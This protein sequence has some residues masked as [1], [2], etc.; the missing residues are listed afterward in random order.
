M[1][2]RSPTLEEKRAYYAKVRAANYTASLRLEGFVVPPS[3]KEPMPTP[4][5][6]PD[7]PSTTTVNPPP[8]L[9]SS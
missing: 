4:V 8:D 7:L 1:A 2:H 5:D 3:S 9:P 6:P